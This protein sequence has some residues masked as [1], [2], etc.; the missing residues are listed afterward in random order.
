MPRSECRFVL[1]I[2]YCSAQKVPFSGS[3]VHASSFQGGRKTKA[4]GRR[5]DTSRRNL[6]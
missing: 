1:R 5:N 6:A 2:L 3:L 4:I